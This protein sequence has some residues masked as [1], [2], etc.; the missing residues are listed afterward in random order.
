MFDRGRILSHNLL[1]G[2]PDAPFAD[3]EV[4]TGVY[5]YAALRCAD[6]RRDLS[7]NMISQLDELSFYGLASVL[8]M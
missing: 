3:M 7:F 1:T 5:G 2:L 8:K 6:S 4:A